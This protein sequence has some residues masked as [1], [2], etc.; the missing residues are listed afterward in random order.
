MSWQD[1]SLQ[2][3]IDGANDAVKKGISLKKAFEGIEPALWNPTEEERNI[4]AD[5]RLNFGL[6]YTAMYMPRV[7][8][9][10]LSTLARDQTDFLAWNVYQPNNGDPWPG[11]QVSGW[12]SNAI[13]PV[14]RNKAISVAAHATARLI[15]PKIFASDEGSEPQEDAAHVIKDLME[16][17]G[18]KYN[19]AWTMLESVIQALVAP[20]SIG[21]TEYRCTYRNVKRLVDGKQVIEKMLDED[22]SGFV[23]T[24]VPVDQLFIENFFEPDIQKQAWLIWRRVQ[25]NDLLKQKYGHLPNWKHVREGMQLMYNDANQGF[26][27][28]YDPNMRKFVGEEILYYEKQRDLFLVFVN[29]VILSSFDNPN[30]REDKLYPF[31]KFGYEFIRH[32]CFYFKSLVFKVSHDANIIN[33]LYPMIIDGTYLNLMPPLI[34]RGGDIITSDVVVP[35]M[36]TTLSSPDAQLGPLKMASDLKAGLDAMFKVEESVNQSSE[37]PAAPD[38]SG[39]QTAYEISIREQERNNQLGLFVQMIGSMVRQY[40]R[41]RIG[42]ILQY[43]TVADADKVTDEAELVYKSFVMQ[44]KDVKGKSKFK[45]IK[46][47]SSMMGAGST[48]DESYKT[49]KEQGGLNSEVELFRVNPE[50]IRN[51]KYSVIISPD[52]LNPRSED[53]ERLYGL[54]LYDRAI[55]NP[56]IDQEAI[57][58]ELL[59]KSN[60]RTARDPDKF[61]NHNPQGVPGQ[62]PSVPGIVPGAGGTAAKPSSP[63]NK[64]GLPQANSLVK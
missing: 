15:F 11:D 55:A 23:D 16:W 60:P 36:V 4:T 22:Q 13:R 50:A 34:N 29:G 21:H 18:E 24:I 7:E 25:S 58:R 56:T 59:L 32:Q 37:M 39:N 20:A 51:L 19:Y 57:T 45:K 17:A 3:K 35:G 43:L 48:L 64:F 10:D 28:V 47:D 53:V 46:F 26:Y 61:I 12:R 63:A 1:A 8:W 6:A 33:T 31:W 44:A 49:L 52:V 2:E 54:E 9:N 30:P 62:M 40:G 14:E 42:D 27:Y 5:V 38:K 41:L